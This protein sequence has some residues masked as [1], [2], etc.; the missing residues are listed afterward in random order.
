[1]SAP[2]QPAPP[3]ARGR[4]RT[5][6]GLLAARA[7]AAS[8][9]SKVF[10]RTRE[11]DVTYREFD[12][13]T[14]RVAAGLAALGVSPGQAVPLL[15][16]NRSEFLLS[17][18]GLAKLGAVMVPIDVQARGPYLE[19]ALD[20][21]DPAVV[22][23]EPGPADSL[24][25]LK[26]A[27]KVGLVIV[28]ASASEPV[29]ADGLVRFEDL[30]RAEPIPERQV[31]PSD[32]AAVYFTSGSTG[33]PKGVLVS[34]T[35]VIRRAEI[36]IEEFEIDSSD[37]VF[38]PFPLHHSD[39][40]NGVVAVALVAGATAAI[41]P[42][43]SASQYWDDVRKFGATVT[44]TLGVDQLMLAK[45][46]VR[47]D[48]ADNP[49][50]LIIGAGPIRPSPFTAEFERRFG[51]KLQLCYGQGECWMPITYALGDPQREGSCGRPHK[52]FEVR[53][54]DDDDRPVPT[55]TTGEIALR[56][57]EPNVHMGG[58]FQDPAAT[59]AATRNLWYHTGDLA[60]QDEDGYVFFLG[61]KHDVIRRRGEN[62]SGA[63]VEEIV[64][65]HPAVREVAAIAVPS[66]LAEDD[67]KICVVV[68]EGSDLTP[69]E[70]IQFCTERMPRFMVPR[71]IEL[72]AALPR[73]A[74]QKVAKTALKQAGV[75]PSTWDREQ[76]T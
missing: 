52:S 67:L 15:L 71:Y 48:D 46:P 62:I 20:L 70:L 75:T 36:W 76:P 68:A 65:A 7:A 25:Q 16:S 11:Q 27:G 42:R 8:T 64:G 40:S 50:R 61:R 6:G 38:T 43:F 72:F 51:V 19:T 39:A 26:R 56:P 69:A 2:G 31:E 34:H 57:T 3:A 66:E 74:T 5:L 30:L 14:N 9:A 22:I 37:V 29:V 32:P 60:Y 47:A 73:T 18:F 41:Q 33:Q 45:Q 12:K 23:T 24:A 54:F 58:Y 59:V 35:S 4:E 17:W 49:L 53:I 44:H 21:A 13:L 10:L 55:G 1:V 28:C 63:Q